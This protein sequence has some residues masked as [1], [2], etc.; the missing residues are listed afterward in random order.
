[1]VICKSCGAFMRFDPDSQ[2]VKCDYCDTSL[3]PVEAL[4]GKG[5]DKVSV[6]T[7]EE[8]AETADDEY[9][10]VIYTC[11]QCGGAILW[12]DDTAATFC[13]YCGASAVTLE[14]RLD[15]VKRPEK[16]IPFVIS[17][18]KAVKSYTDTVKKAVFAPD[19]FRQDST[20]SMFR[21]IYM[22]YW[23][24]DISHEGRMQV[25]GTQTYRRGDYVHTEFYDIDAQVDAMC[26]GIS[27]D[28]SASFSDSMSR[29]IAPFL[30]QKSRDFDEVFLSGF[31]ADRCTVPA[32]IYEENAVNIAEDDISEKLQRA[33]GHYSLSLSK[34]TGDGALAGVKQKLCYFP[35]WFLAIRDKGGS[36]LSYAVVNGQTGKVAAD[37]PVD[38]KKY[39]LGS[40]LLSLPIIVIL[41]LFVLLSPQTILVAGVV[42]AIIS[43][44]M[45]NKQLDQIYTRRMNFDDRGI[46][47]KSMVMDEEDAQREISG[48][49]SEKT[50]GT[51]TIALRDKKVKGD[52]FSFMGA[53]IVIVY[54]LF[55]CRELFEFIPSGLKTTI[56]TIAVVFALLVFIL[57]RMAGKN[58]VQG[59]RV[60][61]MPFWEKFPV[62]LKPALAIVAAAV[63][64]L[65]NPVHDYFYYG[66]AIVSLLLVL[67]SFADLVKGHN[68]LCLRK[69]PQMNKRGGDM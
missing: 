66:T 43:L 60:M 57:R 52:S 11:P 69:P 6:P 25:K 32:R 23:C 46:V 28:A 34:A 20:V 62:M 56:L 51:G 4:V 40:V 38:Y 14:K 53:L 36:H 16:V 2:R 18:E 37:L 61:Y 24:Y 31:Y 1:M 42:F 17:K 3:D 33:M 8:G 63:V 35:V 7:G 15:S 22:P 58:R 59:K 9:E 13:S 54:I 10:T 19:Y 49:S 67:F 27:F 64:A 44:I 55:Q 50:F 68:E 45:L 47:Y 5:S 26:S 65:I 48:T 12:D 30:M 41:N 39:L 29:A 21:G